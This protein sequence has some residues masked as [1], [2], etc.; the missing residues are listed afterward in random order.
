M[1]EGSILFLEK[2]K[3]SFKPSLVSKGPYISQVVMPLNLPH[4]FY[5]TE[6]S[7][8]LF[9]TTKGLREGWILLM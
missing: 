7:Q 9:E 1:Y 4:F 3:P 2:K 6:E 8:L 5:L